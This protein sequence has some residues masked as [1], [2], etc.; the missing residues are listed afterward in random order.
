FQSMYSCTYSGNI[1]NDGSSNNDL[2]FVPTDA[3]IDQM[4]FAELDN[5]NDG[6][7]D[8]TAAAQRAALRAYIEQDDYL[9][10]RRGQYAERNASLSPWFSRWDIRVLQ[11]FKLGN[12]NVI[13]LS[14]DLLNAG[15]FLSSDWGV[16]ERPTTTQPIGVLESVDGAFNPIFAP[17]ADNGQPTFTFDPNLTDTF[18]PDTG[19][20]SRWQLQFGLRYSF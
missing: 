20:L 4:N 8:N 9:S 14:I 19:L 16:R 1:N 18:T 11:D 13:Q 17:D 2:I 7:I 3:Q 5:D 12:G 15:N 10:E 6:N